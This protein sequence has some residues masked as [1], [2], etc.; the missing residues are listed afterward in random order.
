MATE[1]G[2]STP[3][4]S[5]SGL[6]AATSPTTF[7][8]SHEIQE[9][10]EEEV[11]EDSPG[12]SGRQLH[13]QRH[14]TQHF[15][16]KQDQQQGRSDSFGR[17]E[18]PSSRSDPQRPLSSAEQRIAAAIRQH[19]YPEGGWGWVVCVCVCLVNALS[20][21]MQLNY[22]VMH[23]AAVQQF[24]EEHESEAAWLGSASLASSLFMSP[25]VV[26]WCRRKSI[27]VTAVVGGLVAALGCLFS[28]FASQLHQGL[29]SQGLVLG[30]G[31]GM[32]RDAG[33]L[34]LGQYFKR[35]RHCA[36]VVACA[37]TG[38]GAAV[39]AA[40]LH[41]ALG[42]LGWRYGLQAATGLVSLNFVLG[43]FYRSASL[44]HPHR[45]AIVHLKNQ[46]RKIKEKQPCAVKPPF[47]DF[48]V[49]RTRTVRVVM[50]T[51]ALAAAGLY[52]P[53]FCLV[54]LSTA[55]GI[56]GTWTLQAL[57]GLAS[58]GGAGVAG[59]LLVRHPTQCVLSRRCL[60]QLS[61]LGASLAMLSLG[62]LNGFGGYALF[63]AVYGASAGGVAYALR[64]LV[65]ERLRARHF[66][67]AWGF[68]Q[69][70]QCLPVLVGVPVTGYIN[71]SRQDPK[72][73][74]YFSAAC[75]FAG[76]TS[77]FFLPDGRRE[78][79]RCVH[80]PQQHKLPPYHNHN[81]SHDNP[82][83]ECQCP[84]HHRHPS[85]GDSPNK[86][87]YERADSTDADAVVVRTPC[88]CSRRSLLSYQRST[89]WST[90]L[91]YL[92]QPH[93]L[94][95]GFA[96]DADCLDDE[97]AEIVQQ[98]PELLHCI[99]DERVVVDVGSRCAKCGGM[100]AGPLCEC[101]PASSRDR[102][103]VSPKKAHASRCIH[104]P[105]VFRSTMA[106]I[107]EVTSTV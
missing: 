90:S 71:K 23:A 84:Q 82:C 99:A 97:L 91:E 64:M 11:A 5:S 4:A 21:G 60:C 1:T 2:S 107:E 100:A 79:I 38:L 70:A 42:S 24:G 20:W 67:R 106:P 68:V 27:R 3:V 59:L 40:F 53:F 58:A 32:A 87:S 14:P 94:G 16:T 81:H 50:V 98:R 62:A 88:A 17:P 72:A 36:E 10:A 77:L 102:A 52:T 105:L 19:Y 55:E 28:S 89:S 51:A 8:P 47:F 48:S 9:D 86:G 66:G 45:R 57:L 96:P 7:A 75:T 69:W 37:G 104:E 54:P 29:F 39:M 33:S 78:S 43:A 63:A 25:M 95:G 6:S 76:A 73:G 34:V 18:R 31:L 65:F 49:L 61:L 56:Q 35:R 92:D 13:Q 80:A 85:T 101:A 22:G 46:R 83:G 41:S 93:G 15:K 44:Y 26:A 12:S 74:F 30:L 103:V